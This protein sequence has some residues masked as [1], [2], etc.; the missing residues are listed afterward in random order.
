MA[1]DEGVRDQAIGSWLDE[2]ASAAPAPGGG[3]AAAIS[4][5]LGA[6]L[7]AMVC[8]LTIGKPRYGEHEPLMREALASATRLRAQAIQLAADDSAA[9]G[10]VADAYRLPA[11]TTTD[12]AARG[13]AIQVAL[14]TAAD[15][16][17]RTAEVAAAVIGE[18]A[19]ILDGANVNLISDVAVAAASAQAGL[20]AAEINVDINIKSMR[21]QGRVATLRAEIE[22]HRRQHDTAD[23]IVTTVR[24]RIGQ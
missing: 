17:L 7:V 3:A 21:D 2:L 24:R 15:V 4:A 22:Q 8:N 23:Q 1:D 10:A 12:K 19:R 11:T 16:A 13:E 9:F 14:T 5:A 18:A 6:A 20:T